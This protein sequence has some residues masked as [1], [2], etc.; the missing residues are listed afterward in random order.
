[1]SERPELVVDLGTATSSAALV[2]GDSARLLQEGASDS[3]AWPSAVCAGE[4]GLL[5]GTAAVILGRGNAEAF[6]SGL[7]QDLGE[8]RVLLAGE[9]H[10]PQDL[11]AH[12]L[13]ALR[14]R[15]QQV[16][17]SADLDRLVLVSPTEFRPGDPRLRLLVDAGELAGFEEV[18]LLDEAVAAASAKYEGEELVPGDLV[19]VHDI[20]AGFTASLVRLSADGGHEVL[21]VAHRPDLGGDQVDRL[22]FAH[23][24]AG[25]GDTHEV[26][27]E[28][29]EFTRGL[30]HRVAGADS[31]Q[32]YFRPLK[33]L[34]GLDRAELERLTAPLQEKMAAVVGELLAAHVSRSSPLRA[35]LVVGGGHR[36]PWFAERLRAKLRVPVLATADPASAVVLGAARSVATASERG[37][38]PR[39]ES[40][41]LPVG[42]QLPGEVATVTRLAVRA[43]QDYAPDQVLLV[44]RLPRG[45]LRYLRAGDQ[46][47]SVAAWHVR[48]GDTIVSDQW[49]LTSGP[50]LGNPPETGEQPTAPGGF[51]AHAP[52]EPSRRRFPPVV[53]TALAVAAIAVPIALFVHFRDNTGSGGSSSSSSSPTTSDS[54]SSAS[55]SSSY[56]SSYNYSYSPT[57]TST[58]TT[59]TTSSSSPSSSARSSLFGSLSNDSGVQWSTCYQFSLLN[60]SAADY[61]I[62][63]GSQ[64]PSLGTQIGF[65]KFSSSSEFSDYFTAHKG[66]VGS[67]ADSCT[68]RTSPAPGTTATPP[69]APRSATRP[70]A[71]TGSPGATPARGPSR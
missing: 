30:K 4:D 24:A 60:A 69:S 51:A 54:S 35:A 9:P 5:V 45:G 46:P 11:I 44:A 67:S 32:D 65:A 61:S 22:L 71:P 42:W 15:A 62:A 47:G 56:S 50:L 28:L 12:L 1:M 14:T 34:V 66:H 23:L 40:G 13:R 10:A 52:E 2:V 57:Y 27:R 36:L 7:T 6:R 68:G 70:A 25:L 17:G 33:R 53:A 21:A 37:G 3:W 31:P 49:L 38:G 20:G 58:T 64:S 29:M 19:L 63:C 26:G 39:E 41:Q 43:G 55:S 48:P 16:L 8:P 18:E 59:T